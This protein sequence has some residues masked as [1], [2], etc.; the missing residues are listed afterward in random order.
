V[1]LADF[2]DQNTSQPSLFEDMAKKYRS[3]KLMA[4]VD[5]INESGLGTVTLASQGSHN[6]NTWAMKKEHLSPAYTTRWNDLPKV[7]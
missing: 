6:T 1:M 4:A 3:K 2:Y 7:K 5:Q